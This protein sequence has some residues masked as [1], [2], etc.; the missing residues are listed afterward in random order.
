MLRFLAKLIAPDRAEA[1]RTARGRPGSATS[2]F[3]RKSAAHTPAPARTGR[4]AKPLCSPDRDTAAP[5]GPEAFDP[6]NTGA[7]DR[8]ASWSRIGKRNP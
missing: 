7:F 6:Y 1:G 8:G 3:L 2:E 5:N 4:P